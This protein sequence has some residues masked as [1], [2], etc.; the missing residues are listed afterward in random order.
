MPIDEQLGVFSSVIRLASLR[1]LS[2]GER[3]AV[4][5][6]PLELFILSSC[7]APS[8][9][10][11]LALCPKDHQRP[12]ETAFIVG[13]AGKKIGALEGSHGTVAFGL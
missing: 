2:G 10:D 6:A 7:L 3:A 9:I 12:L 13:W 5:V 11:T 4:A 8:A 1:K